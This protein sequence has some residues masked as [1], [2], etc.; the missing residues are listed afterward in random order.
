METEIFNDKEQS[1][2]A[3]E[4]AETQRKYSQKE[5]NKPAEKDNN[6]EASADVEERPNCDLA[7]AKTPFEK[8]HKT[9]RNQLTTTKTTKVSKQSRNQMFRLTLPF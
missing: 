1:D 9:R 8:S 7:T 3:I 5:A 4:Q 6:Q 2:L